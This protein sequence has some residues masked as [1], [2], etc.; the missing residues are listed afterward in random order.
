MP[1]ITPDPSHSVGARRSSI[2]DERHSG[3]DEGALVRGIAEAGEGKIS[4]SGEEDV[5]GK[6]G[7]EEVGVR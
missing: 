2:F 5:D 7:R 1:K 4:G 6:K 3:Y